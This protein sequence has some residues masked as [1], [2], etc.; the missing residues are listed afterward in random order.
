ELGLKN[1]MILGHF[2]RMEM[3]KN[4]LYL[5]DVFKAYHKLNSESFLILIG[6][7]ELKEEIQK[8]VKEYGLEN[9]GHFLGVGPYH[10]EWFEEM[11]IFL[12]PCLFYW[13][14]RYLIKWYTRCL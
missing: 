9:N 10:Y 2:G 7:G 4:H 5:I 11:D 6:E 8:K 1:E 14:P 12:V 13:V 3:E